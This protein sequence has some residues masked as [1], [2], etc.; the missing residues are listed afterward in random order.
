M[1]I[2][3]CAGAPRD[4]GRDQGS[5]LTPE[6]RRLLAGRPLRR[7]ADRLGIV[8]GATRRLHRDLRR[9]FPHQ[10]EWLEAMARA[11]RLPAPALWRALA[12][13]CGGDS[14]PQLLAV[15]GRGAGLRVVRRAPE[16]AILRRV[17]P[18][19]RF[20]SVELALPESSS[21]LLGVNEAGLVAAVVPG[22]ISGRFAA[23]PLLFAR[24]CL[25]RFE[26]VDAA[27]AWSLSRPAA[28]GGAIVFA[29]ARGER[30]GVDFRGPRRRALRP[31]SAEAWLVVGAAGSETAELA[32]PEAD[33]SASPEVAFASAGAEGVVLGDPYGRRLR[34]GAAE[35]H[36]A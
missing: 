27:L 24:D 23:P 36:G 25:E 31:A 29:D 32:K 3:D 2:V 9:Y 12:T 26:R 15:G 16:R 10:D 11:A 14:P 19:G 17:A 6:L 5:A 13:G 8:G 7:L 4:L 34:L 20:R 21:P 22:R 18:E 28:R 35:W 1:R 33:P 30:A